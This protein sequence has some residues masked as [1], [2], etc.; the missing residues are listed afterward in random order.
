MQ[1]NFKMFQKLMPNRVRNILIVSS[2]YDAFIMEEDEGV[3]EH[4]FMRYRGI[5][6]IEPP[7]FTV[8]ESSEEALEH[9]KVKKFDLVI[10]MPRMLGMN[11]VDFGY[12]LKKIAPDLPIVLLIHSVRNLPLYK[13]IEGAIDKIFVWSGNRNI[14]WAI[15]KWLEDKL[16]TPHDTKMAMVRVLIVVEDNPAAYSSLLPILYRAISKQTQEV[17]DDGL[18]EEHRLLKLR[19][20]TKILLAGTYEE[21]LQLYHDYRPYLIGIFTD[22]SYPMDGKLDDTAGVKFLKHV[23]LEMSDLPL[24][25][26][27]SNPNDEKEAFEIDVCFKDKNSPS[28]HQEIIK[29]LTDHMGFGKFEFKMPNGEV[30][31]KV[32]T[33]NELEK[34]LKTIPG[35][36]LMYHV[37]LNHFSNWLLARSEISL[38]L[39]FR[40]QRYSDFSDIDEIRDYLVS[41]LYAKRVERQKGVVTQFRA[42]E[43]DIDNTYLRIGDGSFG[44][45]ARGLAFIAKFIHENIEQFDEFDDVNIIIPKTLVLST[46]CY[47]EFIEN[48]NFS[49]FAKSNYSDEEIRKYFLEASLSKKMRKNLGTFLKEANFPIAVRSSGLLED[50]QVEAYSGLYSTYMLPNNSANINTRVAQLEGA[51][52]LIYS[53][54][55]SKKAKAFAFSTQRRVEEEKMAIMI[56][57]VLGKRFGQYFYPAISGMAQSY[58]YYPLYHMRADEGVVDISLGLGIILDEDGQ[59]LRFSPKYPQNLPQFSLVNDILKNTQKA[60]YALDL[61]I[62]DDLPQD[63]CC[64]SEKFSLQRREIVDAKD[65]PFVN[66]MCSSYIPSEHVIR[67][68]F[69]LGVPIVTFASILKYDKIPLPQIISRILDLSKIGFGGEVEIEFA[70]NYD[71]KSKKT[72]LILL[73]GRPLAF[74]DID[75]EIKLND[76][77]I[78]NAICYSKSA[79]GRSSIGKIEDIIIV[80]PDKFNAKTSVQIVS[81]IASFNYEL[82]KENRKY[83]LVGLGRW[84]SSDHCLGVPVSWHDI[85]S[86]VAF[87][88]A[89]NDTFRADPSSGTH[90]FQHITQLGLTYMTVYQQN[91]FVDW[92]WF[93][94]Q[95]IIRKTDNIYHVRTAR[96][97]E[98]KIDIR[99]NCGVILGR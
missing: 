19:A 61:S 16:N 32:G 90:F 44:G 84:G 17:L 24:L 36:S 4:V 41:N 51:I 6:L 69:G 79:L 86:V 13:N 65:E 78:D 96:P 43:F 94:S 33:L 26:L 48:N 15:V 92:E 37:A 50:N 67:D 60:F 58:N 52:K 54:V 81:E 35:E 74:N 14:L 31:I 8:V 22:R 27:S 40:A 70:V 42:N 64:L 91:E 46:D 2:S 89:A 66:M 93:K 73:Q 29:F 1:F 9:I 63:G 25:L 80:D 34:V 71:E 76:S 28:L 72:D 47:D 88:E 75:K 23:K 21:A 62:N 98:I 53:S 95:K 12:S 18:N 5:S 59:S 38:A 85:S 39:K 68:S 10:A 55:F 97:L 82:E 77:D 56:Q 20:R 49:D 3:L 7:I 83:L 99:K 57:Q 45:K 30:V 87:V 11:T